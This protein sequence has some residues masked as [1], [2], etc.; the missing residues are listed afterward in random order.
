MLLPQTKDEV[1]IFEISDP[2]IFEIVL[3]PKELFFN[4]KT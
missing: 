1:K 3:T 2:K 4:E